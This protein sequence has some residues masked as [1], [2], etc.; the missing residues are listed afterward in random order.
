MCVKTENKRLK[1]Y[2]LEGQINYSTELG[3]EHITWLYLGQD[4]TVC[5]TKSTNYHVK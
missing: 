5:W 1:E 3:S 2:M 4:K